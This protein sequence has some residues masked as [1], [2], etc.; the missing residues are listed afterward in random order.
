[1][2]EKCNTLTT[3]ME[4]ARRML[5]QNLDALTIERITGLLWDYERQIATIRRSE[6]CKLGVSALNDSDRTKIP[7]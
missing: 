2:C 1:M 3:K 4:L 7:F 6:P 5:R